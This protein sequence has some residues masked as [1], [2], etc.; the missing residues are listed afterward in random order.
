[1]TTKVVFIYTCKTFDYWYVPI[2]VPVNYILPITIFI[3]QNS[4][5]AESIFLSLPFFFWDLNFINNYLNCPKVTLCT[6]SK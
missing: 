3:E 4:L 5:N 6:D 1:M 2:H